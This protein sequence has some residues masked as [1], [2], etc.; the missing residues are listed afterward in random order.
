MVVAYWRYHELSQGDRGQRFEAE[1]CF[2]AWEAVQDAVDQESNV[3]A[4]LDALL[5]APGADACY[6]GAGPVED[7]LVDHGGRWD[8]ALAERCRRSAQWRQA[9]TCA[10]VTHQ[11]Q[12]TQLRPFLPPA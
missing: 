12:L 8:A 10:S 3:L 1:E 11:S 2:W 7:L 6:V 5:D 4:L 9:L